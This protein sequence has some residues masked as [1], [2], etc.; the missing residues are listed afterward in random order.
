M[1]NVKATSTVATKKDATKQKPANSAS[2]KTKA[3]TYLAAPGKLAECFRPGTL[4]SHVLALAASKD[5]ITREKLLLLCNQA[6]MTSPRLVATMRAG[7]DGRFRG[8]F[9]K[10]DE[11]NNS[12]RITAIRFDQ[13]RADEIAKTEANRLAVLK[14]Q[15]AK[16][17]K[18]A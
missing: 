15:R 2:A 14:T 18:T 8:F 5:G 10:L 3:P 7:T 1:K 16:Y 11:S 17:A 9:W 6:E 4:T 13:K 12:Y